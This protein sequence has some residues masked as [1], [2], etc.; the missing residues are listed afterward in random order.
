VDPA[1][2]EHQYDELAHGV[3]D[4]VCGQDAHAVVGFVDVELGVGQVGESPLVVLCGRIP[5]QLLLFLML[6]WPQNRVTAFGPSSETLVGTRV[7]SANI[8]QAEF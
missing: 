4:G 1:L 5:C 3:L 8:L 6:F 2:L 7:S